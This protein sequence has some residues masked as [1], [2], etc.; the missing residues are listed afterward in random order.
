MEKRKGIGQGTPGPGRP[1]GSKNKVTQSMRQA[2]MEAFEG[3]GGVEALIEWGKNPKNQTAF[4]SL[5]SKLIPID[6]TTG[7]EKISV[8]INAP[9]GGSKS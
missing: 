7:G 2:W 8:T 4:Y 1:E 9:G 3:V 6:I 5:A